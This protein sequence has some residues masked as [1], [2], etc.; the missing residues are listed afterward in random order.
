MINY[1]QPTT[2]VRFLLN[3]GSALV[4]LPGLTVCR[5]YF[6]NVFSRVRWRDFSRWLPDFTPTT[7]MV[8]SFSVLIISDSS[9]NILLQANVER[10]RKGRLYK[11]CEMLAI[12]TRS[13]T[14]NQGSTNALRRIS[15]FTYLSDRRNPF[16]G[17]QFHMLAK[18][19]PSKILHRVIFFL[20]ID[21]SYASTK[22]RYHTTNF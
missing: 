1:P 15:S 6:R 22:R 12:S 7:W 4:I 21:F 5:Q 19:L 18:T 10:Y 13:E 8:N 16:C 17:K 3:D 14:P 11:C 2:S 9:L 20:G